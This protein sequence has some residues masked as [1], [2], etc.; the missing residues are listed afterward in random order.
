MDVLS[1]EDGHVVELG[2][3]TTGGTKNETRYGTIGTR[4]VVVKI[5]RAHG[6]LRNEEAALDFLAAAGVRVPRVVVSGTTPDGYPYLVITRENGVRTTT[7]EG[8]WRFGRDLASL[9]DVSTDSC[10]LPCITAAEFVT[11]HRD[12][13]NLVRP[14][15]T[16]ALADEIDKAIA[17]VSGTTR[18]VVTHGDPGSG[19]YLDPGDNDGVGVLLDWETASVS[20]F[21]LDLGRA[22]FIGLMDLGRSGIPDQLATAL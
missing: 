13:L 20:P 16:R 15:L 4:A 2:E 1:L 10:P 17:V 18:L 19:N 21:G 14:L 12:R 5:Q 11:D 3:R 7:P 8:W 22:A 9:L 6:R